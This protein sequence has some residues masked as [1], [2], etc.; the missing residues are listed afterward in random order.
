[1]YIYIYIHIHR[2]THMYVHMSI[3]IYREREIY[4]YTCSSIVHFQFHVQMT[5]V[6]TYAIPKNN[7]TQILLIK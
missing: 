3:Y 7:A 4:T 5:L 1:M 2:Y 6:E